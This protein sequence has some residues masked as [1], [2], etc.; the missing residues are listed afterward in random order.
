[1]ATGQGNTTFSFVRRT[2]TDPQ[3]MAENA[4]ISVFNADSLRSVNIADMSGVVNNDSL[5][6]NSTTTS[7]EPRSGS[8]YSFSVA[9][10]S[11]STE[12][13]A[14]GGTLTLAG[15]T[16]LSTVGSA[17]D[18]VTFN[19]DNT[20]VAAGT[21]TLA[22]ITVDAQGRLTSASNGTES[23]LVSSVGMSNAGSAGLT[24]TTDNSTTTPVSYISGG[25][26]GQ[27]FGGTGGN[28]VNGGDGNILICQKTGNASLASIGAGSNITISV[29]ANTIEIGAL[30]EQT[31]STSGFFQMYYDS[32]NA[33]FKYFKK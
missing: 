30:A 3:G 16:A 23:G 2:S 4:G 25:L 33:V 10:D 27:G 32:T 13:I 8:M 20:T 6:Y 12:V 28:M 24:W 26:L 7:W 18:T 17:A 19:L 21:Y 31:S 1:M 29:G 11:G 14:E 9:G 5:V 22:N 15:G